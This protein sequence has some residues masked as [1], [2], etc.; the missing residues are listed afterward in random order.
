MQ[1][2][3]KLYDELDYLICVAYYR[4]DFFHT[5]LFGRTIWVL[6][7]QLKQY[8]YYLHYSV[9][10]RCSNL[11]FPILETHKNF[12]ISEALLEFEWIALWCNGL[13]NE[14]GSLTPRYLIRR[15]WERS[16]ARSEN[17]QTFSNLH[18]VNIARITAMDTATKEEPSSI[19]VKPLEGSL[20]Y[21]HWR[22]SARAS[23]ILHDSLLLVLGPGRPGNSAVQKRE[24]N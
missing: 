21:P 5:L 2:F 18:Q 17:P 3:Q 13:L 6:P 19:K 14:Q 15:T 24:W 9:L 10:C 8:T 4:M 11:V 7:K 22:R 23:L 12:W 1:K 20:D 16:W